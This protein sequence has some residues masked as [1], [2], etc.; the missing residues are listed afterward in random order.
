MVKTIIQQRRAK[1]ARVADATSVAPSAAA[2]GVAATAAATVRSPSLMSELR[3]TSAVAPPFP[4]LHYTGLGDRRWVIHVVP[5]ILVVDGSRHD[6]AFDV[7]AILAAYGVERAL[8]GWWRSYR[9]GGG[10]SPNFVLSFLEEG[11]ERRVVAL[12]RLEVR[13]TQFT[14]D[15]DARMA[16]IAMSRFS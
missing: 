3:S 1:I 11:D 16:H 13:V 14:S 10:P 7:D 6:R 9:L 5:R 2:P 4:S 12:L 15:K 8:I